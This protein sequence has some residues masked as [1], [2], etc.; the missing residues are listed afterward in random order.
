MR[1]IYVYFLCV[2]VFFGSVFC[3]DPPPMPSAEV[4][5]YEK[6][7]NQF[8]SAMGPIHGVSHTSSGDCEWTVK[9]PHVVLQKEGAYFAADAH[10]QCG[11]INQN[12]VVKGVMDLGYDSEK[13]VIS[14]KVKQASFELNFD[15]FGNKVHIMDVD[16]SKYYKS[17]FQFTGPQPLQSQMVLQLPDGTTKNVTMKQ[18]NTQLNLD[19][20]RIVVSS[21]LEFK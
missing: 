7:L 5:I 15:F 8:F 12:T 20:H 17:Q 9:N 11:L 14:A 6:T 13:N 10:I 2:F 16:I 19:T 1:H 3:Q 4:V 18:S 21:D